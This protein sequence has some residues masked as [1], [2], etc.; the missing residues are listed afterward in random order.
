[1]ADETVKAEQPSFLIDVAESIERL[2]NAMVSI[3]KEQ[4][5]ARKLLEE[6]LAER[7]AI[8]DLVNG[9]EA[10]VKALES[11]VEIHHRIL[12]ADLP[13]PLPKG[14]NDVN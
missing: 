9:F 2:A 5:L 11:L 7:K 10:R 6:I 12:K 8:V 13:P 3:A 1:M 4:E 14:T